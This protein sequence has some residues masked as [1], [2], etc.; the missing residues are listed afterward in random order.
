MNEHLTYTIWG[1]VRFFERREIKDAIA[2]L[3]LLSNEADDDAFL[4][5]INVPSRRLGRSFIDTLKSISSST[6]QPLMES[7]RENISLEA[8]NR[9]GA[10]EFLKV[11]DECREFS[12]FASLDYS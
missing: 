10:V 4:R 5:I 7:L 1:G 8:L 2:Y 3:R 9:P 11:M 6:G 12:R